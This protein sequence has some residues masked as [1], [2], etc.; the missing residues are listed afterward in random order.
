MNGQ[1]RRKQLQ[2]CSLALTGFCGHHLG[3][4]CCPY[5]RSWKAWACS[6]ISRVK[7]GYRLTLPLWLRKKDRTP[8][9]SMSPQSEGKSCHHK[10]VDP[11]KDTRRPPTRLL[12][13]SVGKAHAMWPGFVQ[14]FA[15]VNQC[16][17]RPKPEVM[18]GACN[19]VDRFYYHCC[20]I[21]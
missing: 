6:R 18:L 14:T 16:D 19:G 20:E 3:F 11:G 15:L 2:I 4:F 13:Q 9:T 17:H 12:E 1:S 5:R 8:K 10:M 21:R 7:K